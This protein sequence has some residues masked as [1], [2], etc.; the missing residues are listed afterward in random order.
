MLLVGFASVGAFK[1]VNAELLCE[2]TWCSVST[3][4]D[5]WQCTASN[6]FVSDEASVQVFGLD[7]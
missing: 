3:I 5:P 1:S 2:G 4:P 7:Y 6:K